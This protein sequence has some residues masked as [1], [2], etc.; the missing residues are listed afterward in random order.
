MSD[1]DTLEW[2]SDYSLTWSDFKA[3]YNPAIY[4]DSH[5]VIKY[6]FTWTVNSDAIDDDILFFIENIQLFTEFHPLLSWVRPTEAN[7]V[8]L[9]HEQ[10]TFDLAEKINRENLKNLQNNFYEKQ[11]A[12]IDSGK[13]IVSEIKKLEEL[14]EQQSQEYHEITN[15]GKNKEKQSEYNLIFDKLR[16]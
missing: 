2:S 13:M 14:F 6:R 12:K 11:F 8:L 4:E 3:E 7:D 5:S 15:F 16:L 10:G 9:K 1:I